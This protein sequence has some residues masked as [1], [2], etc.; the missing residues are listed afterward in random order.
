MPPRDRSAPG[1]TCSPVSGRGPGPFPHRGHQPQQPGRGAAAAAAPGEEDVILDP[2]RRGADGAVIR[3][4]A[5]RRP[6]RVLH[7]FCASEEIPGA[8]AHWR[9]CGY[10]VRRVVP[11]TCSPAP[12]NWRHWSCYRQFEKWFMVDGRNGST[13]IQ[14]PNSKKSKLQIPIS[15]TK[16]F[17][18]L[19]F[20]WVIWS[21]DIGTYLEFG[22]WDLEFESSDYLTLPVHRSL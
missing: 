22:A 21:L 15:K 12:R 18:C 5:R 16:T 10:F 19:F 2:P 7:L 13:R 8:L 14:A 11:W 17:L 1:A 20:V 6:G 4:I 3:S 9:Q